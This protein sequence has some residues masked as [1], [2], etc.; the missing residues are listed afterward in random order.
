MARCDEQVVAPYRRFALSLRLWLCSSALTVLMTLAQSACAQN[1]PP[2]ISLPPAPTTQPALN[3]P[4]RI[5]RRPATFGVP[6]K[7]EANVRDPA[8]LALADAAGRAVPAQFRVLARWRA[9]VADQG[10]PIKWLLVDADVPAGEYRLVLSNQKR[11]ESSSSKNS[12]AAAGNGR[13]KLR[14]AEGGAT[15]LLSSF[16]LDGVERLAQ[17]MTITLEQPRA[18]ML[19]GQAAV[20]A[21][22]LRVNDSAQLSVG[23]QVRFEHT[24][25]LLYETAAGDVRFAPRGTDGMT[26][27]RAYRLEEGTRREEEVFVVREES[28]W[29]FTRVPL[30]SPHAIRGQVRDL[31]AEKETATVRALRGQAVTLAAPLRQAHGYFERV[32]VAD[33]AAKPLS[34]PLNL[35]AT[36]DRTEFEMTGPLRVVIRQDGHF[37]PADAKDPKSQVTPLRFT[38]RYHVY[39]GQPFV[40]VQLRL[41]NA[42]AYGFGGDR[43]QQL[44]FAQHVLVRSLA[45][46]LPFASD[47]TR[48]QR[49]E[50]RGARDKRVATVSV[51]R[52]DQS[53]EMTVPE[54]SENFP[55]LIAADAGGVRFDVL[56]PGRSDYI[57]DGARAKTV[58]FYLGLETRSA[59]ALT[60]TFGAALDPAYVAETKAV[61]PAF[62][63]KRNW[64][65]VFA[66]DR[67]MAVAATRLERWLASAY[68]REAN[69]PAGDSAGL[70]VFEVRQRDE[71]TEYGW[72]NFGDLAWAD[73]YSNLH[74]DLPFILLREYLRTTDGRAFQVG[75]EMARYRSDW[76]QYH[77]DDYWDQERTV[78]LRGLAF[79]EKGEHGS[80]R[81]PIPSHTWIEGL[82]LYWALTGDEA[83]HE[84]AVEAG[85][86]LARREFTYY[87]SLSWN[88]PRWVGWPVLGLMAA[89]RYS[90]ERKYLDQAR[91]NAYLLVQAEESYGRK[92][93]FIPSGSG[94][95]HAVQPFIWS[96][97]AQLGVIEYWRET[98]D[99]RVADYLVRIADWL[100][101]K[102]GSSPVL[103]G[104]GTQADGS[105]QPVA[106]PYFWYP[107]K[108]NEVGSISLGMMSL[109]VL[110][111][112]AQ[113]TG[114]A[115]LQS[116]ARQ[117]FRDA[118][119]Y[120]DAPDK[121]GLNASNL[122]PISFRSL[123]YI[124]SYPKIYGQFGLFVPDYLALQ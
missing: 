75:S 93:Y 68:A 124:G 48:P 92:G 88:E 44:P 62:I 86:A 40:R 116:K 99:R 26:A 70:S 17:P 82:W 112:A 81:E 28:G 102:G 85:E 66:Q 113:I 120:R 31:T 97:Y 30:R 39:S 9:P 123:Q 98:G 32:V 42:G 65:K 27:G 18:V 12:D 111:T 16:V 79:Y 33:P 1:P 121:P 57:F 78:N 15:S 5:T 74:Y 11:A 24:G 61:R 90:G 71:Q 7:E 34:L 117:L 103:T 46:N 52:N 100:V 36:A 8:N 43:N 89:W 37:R 51:G 29:L 13:V 20:G 105:Y 10:R 76:G 67:T 38:L 118:T 122:S 109:P 35:I 53:L 104:G 110:A 119:Y 108:A 94:F 91:K 115:D 59:A 2:P 63:E 72:R 95:G 14:A 25:E 87:N 21:T 77:A 107:D 101:G 23:A 56:P 50:A 83:V 54:F 4:L 60:N 22:E 106:V 96:G 80:Y 114:R 55:K 19:V 6:L 45:V 41:V 64:M 84:S 73:G 47:L 3:V 49:E 58:E 69:D